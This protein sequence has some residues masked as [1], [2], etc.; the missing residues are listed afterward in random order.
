[1]RQGMSKMVIFSYS[2]IL[3]LSLFVSL[4]TPAFAQETY[5]EEAHTLES[6]YETRARNALNNLLRP[7]EY[8]VSVSAKVKDDASAVNDYQNE[9]DIRFLPGF[10]VPTDPSMMPANNKLHELK[11]KITVHLILAD[12]VSPEKDKLLKDV[13]K[14]K[15]HISEETGDVINISRSSIFVNED[16]P[17]PDTLPELSWKMWVLI[18]LIALSLL[19]AAIFFM[20][21]KAKE[22][23][24]REMQRSLPEPVEHENESDGDEAA[25]EL[26]PEQVFS[27]EAQNMKL[28]EE[29]VSVISEYPQMAC[30]LVDEMVEDGRVE[31]VTNIMQS[32]GWAIARR[33]FG[34]LSPQT[35]GKIGSVLR[36]RGEV[37]ETEAINK[38]LKEFHKELI[39]KVIEK[40]LGG[41]DANPF[42]FLFQMEEKET[43]KLLKD[44]SATQ[45]A[46]VCLHASADQVRAILS[47]LPFEVQ[48][49]VI[50]E[51][52]RLQTLP[53]S[54]IRTAAKSLRMKLEML[55]KAPELDVE[56]PE[57]AAK[58]LK[59]L[60]AEREF[61]LFN[62]LANSNP[63]E[64]E[65]I[66]RQS[67]QFADLGVYP[68]D[69]VSAALEPLDVGT[70]TE[71]L[72]QVDP[73]VS[74]KCFALMPPK[75]AKMVE[76]DLQREDLQPPKSSVAESR[77]K[78][79]QSIEQVLTERKMKVQDI[80]AQIDG[81]GEGGSGSSQA[82]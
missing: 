46:V 76:Y 53:Q 40:S 27:L 13:L 75:K 12:S 74:E 36:Q 15:L 63:Q 4:L 66:R 51:I 64:A 78:I 2:I 77:R 57:Y 44:E 23:E 19:A 24:A 34:F 32:L 73:S 33:L 39:A 70:L 31:V 8:T 60:P 16:G 69:I 20:N 71:A 25:A 42:S 59:T 29:I 62:E 49:Q 14:S 47:F 55:R 68:E 37:L 61:D 38:S 41:D 50:V 18:L 48:N 79:V 43:K 58:L 6:L 45:I 56:G 81:G 5:L 54:A 7:N 80:W 22:T 10:P 11:A 17:K 28:K 30:R 21:K 1:M 52:S 26:A 3:S 82:A 9:L 35:W 72:F 67:V 65:K